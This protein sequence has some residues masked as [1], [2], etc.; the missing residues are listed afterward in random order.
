MGKPPPTKSAPEAEFV[1]L[2]VTAKS[3]LDVAFKLPLRVTMK[4]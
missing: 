2:P 3:T 4:V 1:P